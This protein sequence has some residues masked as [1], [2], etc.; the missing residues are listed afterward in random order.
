MLAI[1]FYANVLGGA[2][3]TLASAPFNFVRLVAYATPP[4]QPVPTCRTVI[5]QL[6]QLAWQVCEQTRNAALR[7]GLDIYHVYVI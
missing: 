4:S 5:T 2:A 1:Y 3:G 7:G 6:L